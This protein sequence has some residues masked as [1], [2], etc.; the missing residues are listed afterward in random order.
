MT[1]RSFRAIGTTATV[2][3]AGE[4]NA[5]AD[6]A[7]SM[8]RI[9]LDM[10]D[11]TCSRFR[12]DSEL[13][14]L[15]RQAGGATVVSSLL[16]EALAIAVKVADMTNGAVDPTVGGAMAALGYDC[17]FEEIARGSVYPPVTSAP[18]PGYGCIQLDP[19]SNTVRIP[20]GVRLDLGSSAKA[21]GADQAAAHIADEIG[22]SVLVSI[23]GDVAVNGPPPSGGW[24][25]GIATDSGTS[26]AEATHRVAIHQG[27]LASSGTLVRTW[28]RGGEPV[29]HI[30]D[31]AT[32]RSASTFWS[33]VS[34]SGPTC[35][36]ANALSTAAIVWGQEA[37]ERLQ[38]LGQ[39]VRLVRHDGVVFALGGWPE[40]DVS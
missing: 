16:F 20:E 32:G 25:I 27:G 24:P 36:N 12:D 19:T 13:S 31:P 28:M 40:D 14:S 17:D 15:H 34:A 30:V 33:L 6:W 7:A 39:A 2:V 10:L 38:P 3:V 26:P 5:A 22:V 1:S 21:F 18:A 23:G 8:L 35:V 4:G 9:E 37:L 11:R 29:H